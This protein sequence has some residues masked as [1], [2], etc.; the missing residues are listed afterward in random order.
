[1][2]QL[3]VAFLSKMLMPICWYFAMVSPTWQRCFDDTC[4]YSSSFRSFLKG[5]M[6]APSWLRL[7]TFIHMLGE[8]RHV[9][10]S[11]R[12]RFHHADFDS[13][14][15]SIYTLM[16]FVH[17]EDA[18]SSPGKWYSRRTKCWHFRSLCDK[19]RKADSPFFSANLRYCQKERQRATAAYFFHWPKRRCPYYYCLCA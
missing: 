5:D 9:N 12:K 2:Y 18:T 10:F 1:M 13:G 6:I 7:I 4:R 14:W 17:P 11:A 19:I 15:W 16:W 8:I 3:P